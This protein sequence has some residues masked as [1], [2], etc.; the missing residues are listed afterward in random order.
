[1]QCAAFYHLCQS[2]K[3]ACVCFDLLTSKTIAEKK[4]GIKGTA[5][6]FQK[7]PC[8]FYEKHPAIQIITLITLLGEL[9][10]LKDVGYCN[11]LHS[12]PILSWQ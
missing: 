1:M 10:E 11:L 3:R 7:I 8:N 12:V 6:T 4:L 2:R 5:E 9:G